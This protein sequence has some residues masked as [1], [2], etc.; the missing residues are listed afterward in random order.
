MANDWIK[1]CSNRKG[2]CMRPYTDIKINDV[3][4]TSTGSEWAVINKN[5][6]EKMIQVCMLSISLPAHLN[7]P[8]W[9]RN[10]D[11]LF[12]NRVQEG[13]IIK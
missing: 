4:K 2:G 11:R 3:Y 12:N 8:F 10:T 13:E 7:K 6:D 1:L 9:K 5:D